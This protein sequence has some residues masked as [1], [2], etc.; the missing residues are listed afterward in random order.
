M[1]WRRLY[2]QIYFT[3][4]A[5][6]VIVV[7][8]SSLLWVFVGRDRMNRD[9]FDIIG[10]LAYLSMPAADASAGQQRD[11]L[12][13]LGR[14]LNIDVSLF[15]R[16]RNLV[17][18]SGVAPAMPPPAEGD[19]GWHRIHKGR[20][21]ALRL[22]D[23][24]WLI[25]D[26]G[27]R[28]PHHPLIGIALFLGIA[29]MG[30]ALGAYPFVRRLTRRLERLQKGVE[31]IGAGDLAARVDVQGRDEVAGLAASFNEAA[32]KIE[33]LVD[34]HRLL[35]AN[36]SHELRTPLSRIRMGVELLDDTGDPERR[37]ALRQDIAE[38][39]TLIDEILLMSRLDG[40]SHADLSQAID[41]VALVAEECARYADCSLSGS[42]PEVPGDPRLLRRLVRNLLEN[43]Y[44]HGAPPVEV[45]V[46]STAEAV[47]LTVRDA[48][49]GIADTDRENVFQPFYRAADKQN[50]TGYG[51]GL[52]LARQI[53]EAHGG[54]VTLV[55]HSEARSAIRAAIPLRQAARAPR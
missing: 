17:A 37:A 42:A 24:R 34:A 46:S 1:R 27:R 50:V 39:D 33:T 2:I 40:G 41:F 21:W 26:L 15:D 51:L 3:I 30:V 7:V 22:P 55:P 10:R 48:G 14:E 43:A 11:A 4:I 36:A 18:T 53:N 38:L 5:S 9:V 19:E 16:D 45:E 52:P 20:A 44:A 35:L 13:R 12:Q 49:D 29:A 23:D 6:L 28:G 8:L 54:S 25:V 31:R 47:I 32:E